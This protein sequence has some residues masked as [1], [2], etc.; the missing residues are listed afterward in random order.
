MIFELANDTAEQ[1]NE[2]DAVP[3]MCRWLR[4]RNTAVLEEIFLRDKGKHTKLSAPATDST[5]A[6]RT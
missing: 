5:G 4:Q 6:V 3:E 2:A 1:S